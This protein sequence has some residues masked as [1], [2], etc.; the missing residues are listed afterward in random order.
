MLATSHSPPGSTL[1][2][3]PLPPP[4]PQSLDASKQKTSKPKGLL[5][6]GKKVVKNF[7]RGQVDFFYFQVGGGGGV[8]RV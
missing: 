8:A 2:P 1:P 3:P 4:A 7:Q 5:A 6:I